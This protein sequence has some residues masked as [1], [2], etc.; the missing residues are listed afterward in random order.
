MNTVITY[1]AQKL[2]IKTMRGNTPNFSITIKNSDGSNYDLIDGSNY[3]Q[4]YIKIYKSS[5]F[6]LLN[7]SG[8][9]ETP[10]GGWTQEQIDNPELYTPTANTIHSYFNQALSNLA[11]TFI[12][13]GKITLYFDGGGN[14]QNNYAPWRGRYKYTIYV[15]NS[16]TSGTASEDMV[17]LLYGDWIVV[18]DNPYNAYPSGAEDF[19]PLW[20]FP[21]DD[22]YPDSPFE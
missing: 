18:D 10:D 17:T 8:Y 20:I 13:D 16:A 2:N 15:L 3:D 6:P 1:P 11:D 4:V 14:E 21:I 7:S 19:W 9:G 22:F 5:G 12:E